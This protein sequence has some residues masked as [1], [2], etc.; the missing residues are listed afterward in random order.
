MPIDFDGDEI[1]LRGFART[2]DVA[3]EISLW[4]RLDAG[5]T[6]VAFES[7][8]GQRVGG[9]TGWT[10][11]S[12]KLRRNLQAGKVAFGFFLA[13]TGKAWAD[14]L[15][16]L[17]DGRPVWEL[18]QAE[19]LLTALVRDREF[20]PGSRIGLTDLNP[21]QIDNL[22]T[23]GRVWGFLKYHHPKVTAGQLHWDYELF[24][25]LPEI[26]AAGDRP[27][28]N[29]ILVRWVE[30]LGPVESP[31][32]KA[33][34]GPDLHLRPETAWLEDEAT[35]GAELSRRL[36][37]IHENRPASAKQFYVSLVRHV[38][39]PDFSNE[40]AHAQIKQPDAGFQLLALYRYWNII[41]YWSPYRDL[42]DGGWDAAL[43]EYVPRVALAA[44]PD[45]YKR[46]MLT[47]IAR[48]SD[49]HAN[50]W[51]SIAVRPPVGDH[52]LPVTV[53][54]V[55]QQAVIAG[56]LP[57][58][59]GSPPPYQAGDI[60]EA[61][62]GVPVGKLVEAWTPY[63]AA[64]NQPARLRDIASELTDGPAGD[65][66]VTLRR[67]GES[68]EVSVP[69]VPAASVAGKIV[70]AHDL[71]GGAFRLLSPDIAYVKLSAARG[72]DP[73]DWI[74]QA[75][76]TKGLVIDIRNY[77]SAFV[78]FTLG[79]LLVDRPVEFARFTVADLASPGAFGFTPPLKLQPQAPH[80]RGRV[81]ILVDEIS[82][83]SAE[84][85]T[86]AF[87]TAPEAV[88]VGSVTAGADGNVSTILLPGGLSTM[89]SGVGVFYPDKR[90][91]QR[92]GIRPDVEVHPTV[93]GLREGRDE[94]LEQAI[95]QILGPGIAAEEIRKLVPAQT[96]VGG[97]DPTR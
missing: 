68:F 30:A 25:V 51:S 20:D 15:R 66:K 57:V 44:T 67:E 90:P 96:G 91:T 7:M 41:H 73:K 9:T 24:R 80:Y 58:P 72:A 49:S 60:I 34:F 10:E 89:L 78:V 81:V 21:A 18:P 6:S 47:L 97:I 84:Y 69:R 19:R 76:G 1:E 26:L 94:L 37:H 27:A 74:T 46:E 95:R 50:L 2:E 55:G 87:R 70:V 8:Q 36:R 13:G 59:G 77:P 63:Y 45:D 12:V 4:L 53:R 93:A 75:A 40:A 35:L 82:Q 88:V 42:I 61:L 48:T 83:S 14:D 17:V 65:V 16:L 85:T 31:A 52:R 28:A 56:L 32:V 71:P 3:G 86:M 29:A 54:F 62:D 43:R 22:V 33:S 92:V 5:S 38:K 11:Y 23:L 64:S 39:N 79:Q